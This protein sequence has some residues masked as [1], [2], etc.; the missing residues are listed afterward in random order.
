MTGA[1]Q[2]PQARYTGPPFDEARVYDAMRVGVVTCRPDTSLHDVA[3]MMVMYKIHSV[4]VQDVK[5]GSRPWGIV[6]TLDI[7]AESGGDLFEQKARDVASTDIVTVHANET[8]DV[9]A[10]LMTQHGITHLLVVESAADWPCG[11]ISAR[12]LAAVLAAPPASIL[13]NFAAGVVSEID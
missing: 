4:V 10:K 11:V 8:L 3:R 1:A 12:D 9:A 7:A 13:R 6:T 5:P 2:D